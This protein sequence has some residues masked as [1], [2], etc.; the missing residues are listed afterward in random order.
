MD[1]KI[2][3]YMGIPSTGTIVDTLPYALRS[4]EKKYGDRVEFVYPEQLVKRIFH[5]YAR[6]EIVREFL[7]TDCDVLWFI[8]SDVTPHSDVL[9][10]FIKYYE[11][12]DLAGAPYAV[13][14]R[15]TGYEGPQ[16]VYT[17]YNGAGADG[18]GLKPAEVPTAG[19]GFVDGLATGCILVKR[20]IFEKLQEPWFEF[21]FDPKTRQLVEGEDLGFCKKV[22]ELGYRF[23]V[24]FSK[25]CHH[26]KS[27]DLFEVN[28]YAIDYSNTT[29]KAY[30][31]QIRG[32]VEALAQHVRKQQVRNKLILPK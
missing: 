30:D 18:K 5:D 21:K 8:D 4:I 15:P 32:Q 20:H 25:P 22:N 17:V 3:I 2:K 10:K 19:T 12:W 26:V 14:M 1:R 7:A 29:I 6:N 16:V 27:V 28:N 31:A 24:D 9:D 13:F 23:F 11:E